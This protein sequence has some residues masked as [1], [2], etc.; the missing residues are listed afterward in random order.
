MDF[1]NLKNNFNIL[2][3]EY[4]REDKL[5][6]DLIIESRDI[7]KESKKIIY[8]VHRNDFSSA[9][10]SVDTIKKLIRELLKKTNSKIS[11][12]GYLRSAF[13]EY[14]EALCFYDFVRNNRIPNYKELNVDVESY[15]LGI[16]DFTGELVRFATNNFLKKNYDVVLY[17]KDV[18]EMIYNEL[19]LFDFRS[20]ELRSKFDS[21]KY[22]LKKLEDL[23][24][25][26]AKMKG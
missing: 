17:V 21:I 24:I 19:M 1:D 7:I 25:D 2:R 6:D 18:V 13:Q 20:G 4:E 9:S 15:L 11:D 10:K 12:V 23:A 3:K 14:V 22:S 5:R 26:I 16:C 8:S